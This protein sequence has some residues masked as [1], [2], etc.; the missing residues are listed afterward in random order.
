M[1]PGVRS[2]S[3]FGLSIEN[4]GLHWGSGFEVNFT[5]EK[6]QSGFNPSRMKAGPIAVKQSKCDSGA[7]ASSLISNYLH[8]GIGDS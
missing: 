7:K 3:S 1:R 4:T 6:R 2:D 5:H 8:F